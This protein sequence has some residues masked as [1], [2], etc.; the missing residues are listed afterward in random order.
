M[1][2]ARDWIG[3]AYCARE[4]LLNTTRLIFM[5]EPYPCYPFNLWFFSDFLKIVVSAG[6]KE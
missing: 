4:K 2:E 3:N 6:A 5:P 1:T